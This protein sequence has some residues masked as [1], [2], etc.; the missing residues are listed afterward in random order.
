MFKKNIL[1]LFLIGLFGCF[2]NAQVDPMNLPKLTQYVTDFSNTLTTSQL[3]DLNARAQSYD[4]QTSNQIVAVLF[5]NRNSNELIDIGMNVFDANKI[6]QAGK[7]NGLL[8]LISTEEKKIRIIVWYGLEDKIPD[9]LASRF[10]EENIRPLV[11]SGDFAGAIRMFYDKWIA[12]ISSDEP[13]QI[14]YT[15]N[16]SSSNNN[17]WYFFGFIFWIALSYF[18]LWKFGVRKFGFTKSSGVS[19]FVTTNFSKIKIWQWTLLFFV[20]VLFALLARLLS[21]FFLWMLIGLIF[22]LFDV[23][24]KSSNNWW[25][26]F[27]WWG[28]WWDF[29]WG[30]W[31][32]WWG[33]GSGWWGA[34]D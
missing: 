11:N 16:S 20:A 5:P 12:A 14:Q 32:D 33:W 22:G 1:I 13:P 19:K 15:S 3:A 28:G 21:L 18:L 8:L 23:N 10:I 30:W 6:W 9:L 31:F 24:E 29:G 4:Q 27:G 17:P 25:F 2:V 26:F 34:G 7:N